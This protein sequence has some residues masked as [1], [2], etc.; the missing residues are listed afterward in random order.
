MITSLTGVDADPRKI[1]FSIDRDAP[2][3]TTILEAAESVE[4]KI[5]K[6]KA[7]PAG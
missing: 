5:A 6:R 2:P 1:S 3:K 7:K 4:E